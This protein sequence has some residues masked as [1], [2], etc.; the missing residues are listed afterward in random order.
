MDPEMELFDL[1]YLMA[2]S[3]S[4]VDIIN[5]DAFRRK[6]TDEVER[7]SVEH[8]IL[9]IKLSPAP[10]TLRLLK[11]GVSPQ[12]HQNDCDRGQTTAITSYSL[13]VF[14]TSVLFTPCIIIFYY[15]WELTTK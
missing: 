7:H 15:F 2:S 11:E 8:T 4:C 5:G 1:S 12:E 9:F 10:Y 13:F 3:V 14:S 6:R